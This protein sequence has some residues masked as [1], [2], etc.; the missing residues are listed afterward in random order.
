MSDGNNVV[1]LNPGKPSREGWTQ[2][3]Q[4]ALI[5]ARLGA[6]PELE[7]ERARIAAAKEL[8]CRISWLDRKVEAIR[9]Q[10][11]AKFKDLP[12]AKDGR[13]A[14]G[15]PINFFYNNGSFVI[16]FLTAAVSR[17]GQDWHLL[18]LAD[19]NCTVMDS[20]P[21]SDARIEELKRRRDEG[22]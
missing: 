15:E 10:I 2:R 11:A 7:Y 18:V 1:A 13:T 12:P 9:A 3:E 20:T 5:L 17:R 4:E 19:G 22:A 6:M 16:G 8:K 21:L 14:V